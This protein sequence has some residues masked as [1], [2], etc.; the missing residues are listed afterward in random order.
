MQFSIFPF[1]DWQIL[2]L[3]LVIWWLTELHQL[4]SNRGAVAGNPADSCNFPARIM[5]IL[6]RPFCNI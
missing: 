6:L 1:Q 3:R 2:S 4:S 5:G